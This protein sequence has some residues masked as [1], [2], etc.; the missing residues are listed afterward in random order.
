MGKDIRRLILPIGE[1]V[2]QRLARFDSM[3]SGGRLE[4]EQNGSSLQAKLGNEIYVS[5]VTSCQL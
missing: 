4:E 1:I 2:A 3:R 5:Q